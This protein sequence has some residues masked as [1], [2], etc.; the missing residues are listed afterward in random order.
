MYCMQAFYAF[1]VGIKTVMVESVEIK[2]IVHLLIGLALLP[3][4]D[5]E[6]GLQVS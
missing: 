2:Q 5:A 1:H 3:L 4:Q 6:Q